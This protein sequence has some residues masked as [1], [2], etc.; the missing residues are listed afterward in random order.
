MAYLKAERGAEILLCIKMHRPCAER[1]S[2]V[3]RW[4]AGGLF[5]SWARTGCCLSFFCYTIMNC[6]LWKLCIKPVIL[7][8]A[9]SNLSAF[10]LHLD[11]WLICSCIHKREM[12]VWRITHGHALDSRRHIP[13]GYT[14]LPVPCHTPLAVWVPDVSLAPGRPGDSQEVCLSEFAFFRQKYWLGKA[15]SRNLGERRA[16]GKGERRLSQRKAANGACDQSH[17]QRGPWRRPCSS[18]SV[19]LLPAEPD[20][21]TSVIYGTL[22]CPLGPFTALCMEF[23]SGSL[24]LCVQTMVTS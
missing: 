16:V 20:R 14:T 4:R 13:S 7:W 1:W 3:A 8:A 9:P 6:L 17:W 18:Q 12:Q 21:D 2:V 19:A 10:H 22:S 24:S 15:R 11:P 23:F 5:L